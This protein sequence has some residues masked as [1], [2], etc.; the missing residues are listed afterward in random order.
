MIDS[1]ETG[2]SPSPVPSSFPTIAH[3]FARL[4][5]PLPT[6]FP[7]VPHPRTRR[8]RSRAL[9]PHHCPRLSPRIALSR[10]RPSVPLP[11]R[12]QQFRLL[13]GSFLY[14]PHST[15][16]TRDARTNPSRILVI[17]FRLSP[18]PLSRVGHR[19]YPRLFPCPCPFRR[20]SVGR[21]TAMLPTDSTSSRT[22]TDLTQRADNPLAKQCGLC[23]PWDPPPVLL[24]LLLGSGSRVWGVCVC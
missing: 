7:T 24:L 19:T 3:A 17:A 16:T 6:P 12:H 20:P 11:S 8:P 1:V 21:S 13:P 10:L 9:P 5:P 2:N 4:C 14:D 18:R 15:F 23:V 22:G